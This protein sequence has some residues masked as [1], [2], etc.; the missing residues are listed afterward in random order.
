MFV[1]VGIELWLGHRLSLWEAE[2][3]TD[4]VMWVAISAVA[5]FFKSDEATTKPYFYRRRAAATV[6][7]T[8]LLQFFTNLHPL[9]LIVELFLLPFLA[10]LT[11]LAQYA[12]GEVR[13]RP[14]KR[15][16]EVLIGTVGVVLIVFAVQR[17][18]DG[19]SQT[20]WPELLQKFALPI[21]LTIGL[22]PYI[23]V[24]SLFAAYETTFIRLDHAISD[25]CA[26][27][28]AKVALIVRINLR[29][30]DVRAFT[31]AWFPQL[32]V[33]SSLTAA[34]QVVADFQR[35]RR[36]AER[37]AAE[38]KR[39]L[40]RYSGSDG[41]DADGRRLD[42]REFEQ[43]MNA[44]RLLGE[45]EEGWFHNEHQGRTGYRADLLEV[46]GDTFFADS[47]LPS[48]PG[49]VLTISQDRQS[50]YAWRRTVTGWCF[51]IGAVGPPGDLWEFD[52]PEPPQGFPGVD[53]RWA[54][55]PSADGVN[56]NWGR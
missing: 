54:D 25:R 45:C 15:L 8:E 29:G 41:T 5:L 9:S 2:L 21:W 56:R 43:T 34:R 14:A 37:V 24:L 17:T 52:G 39:R 55:E 20:D 48:D 36:D 53:P 3:T 23:Y 22:L 31:W 12:S 28:R 33:A 35:S 44:L 47:G 11:G 18:I 1:F 19:W 51:A 26:R 13:H 38:K 30:R 16:A 10:S 7:V 40:R 46:I 32:A 49:I 42:R 27:R 4:I 6:G 50:W